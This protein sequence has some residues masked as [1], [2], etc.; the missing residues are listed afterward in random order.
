MSAPQNLADGVGGFAMGMYGAVDQALVVEVLPNRAIAAK[1]LGILNMANTGGQIV[2]PAIAAA[3]IAGAG[4]Y[5][6]LFLVCVI[7]CVLAAACI[8]PIKSAR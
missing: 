6:S 4:G 5:R 2:A 7:A 1:D 3:V 8:L